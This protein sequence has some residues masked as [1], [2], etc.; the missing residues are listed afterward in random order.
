MADDE[1]ADVTAMLEGAEDPSKEFVADM[2]KRGSSF[3]LY[4]PTRTMTLYAD[5]LEAKTSR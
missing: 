2:E 1:E 5:T 3:Y 4:T